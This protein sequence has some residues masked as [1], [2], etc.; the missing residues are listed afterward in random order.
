[1]TKYG[2]LI[3]KTVEEALRFDKENGKTFWNNAIKKELN[4]LLAAKC[5]DFK[6]VGHHPGSGWQWVPLIMVFDVK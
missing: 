2:I 5:F 6:P 3:P 4:A 1:M